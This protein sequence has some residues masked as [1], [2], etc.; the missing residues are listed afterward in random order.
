MKPLRAGG[1]RGFAKICRDMTNLRSAE[2]LHAL[3]LASAQR[4]E[5]ER[6]PRAT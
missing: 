5:A 6:R 2:D 3:Q 4:G 1:L